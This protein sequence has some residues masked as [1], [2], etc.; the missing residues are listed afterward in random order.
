MCGFK[1]ISKTRNIYFLAPLD[2]ALSAVVE[3]FLL[4]Y[5]SFLTKKRFFFYDN[6]AR[7]PS[8]DLQN[9]KKGLAP[10]ATTVSSQMGSKPTN[11]FRDENIQST[12]TTCID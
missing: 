9:V 8:H 2:S 4:F 3:H 11:L 5:R 7:R 12:A 6:L 10:S 1:H